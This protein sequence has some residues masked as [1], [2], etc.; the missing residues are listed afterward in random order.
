MFAWAHETRIRF[1]GQASESGRKILDKILNLQDTRFFREVMV[2]LNYNQGRLRFLASGFD[3]A[4]LTKNYQGPFYVYDL[5]HVRQRIELLR[6]V[7]PARSFFAVKSNSHA[8]I[9]RLMSA[10]RYGADV[11]S[12][13]EIHLALNNGFKPADVIFSGVGKTEK[14]IGLAVALGLRQINVESEPELHRIAK[15]ARLQKKR[16]PIVLRI[17]PDVDPQTHPYITTGF[18]DNKFGLSLEMLP[19]A[20]AICAAQASYLELKGLSIHIGSQICSLESFRGA[21]EKTVPVFRQ[22]QNEG[23]QLSR[24]DIGGGVG[25]DYENGDEAGDE[26]LMS[27]YG[28]VVRDLVLPLGCEVQTEPG[29]WLVA[30]AGVLIA[31]VQYIKITPFRKFV[32]LDTGMHHLMRPAL[33]QAHHRVWPLQQNPE[34]AREVYDVV[35]PICESTDFLARQRE[36]PELREGEFVALLD[37]GAYGAVM[38]NRYN[39][40]DLPAEFVVR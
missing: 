19:Q 28:E 3:L 22:L 15:I 9:L 38:A 37:A 25:I 26:K 14:E 13:G 27:Q 2:A 20:L 4:D 1:H 5:A 24:L 7:M 39:A 36:M 11:V 29:R 10:Q 12:G 21:I 8:E 6:R 33:Y 32:I 18:R 35:G 23:W 17:N 40:H 34:R 30:R 16:V 31:Q